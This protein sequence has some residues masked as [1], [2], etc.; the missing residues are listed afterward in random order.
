MAKI[1]PKRAHRLLRDAK[2][3]RFASLLSVAVRTE[4]GIG[5]APLFALPPAPEWYRFWRVC[6]S[7]ERGRPYRPFLP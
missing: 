6:S 1:P 4:M 3:E 2:Y 5:G 7:A